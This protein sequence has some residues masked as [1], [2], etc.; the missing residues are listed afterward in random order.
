MSSNRQSGFTLIEVMVVVV[1]LGILASIIVPKIMDKPD[2]ARIVKARQDI[3]A[4]QSALDLYRL[5]NYV[6]P[7]TDQ[8]LDAL[9]QKPGGNPAAP[10]W[11]QYLPRLPTDP[12]G[13]P[14]QYLNPGVHGPVDI[15][16]YGA[17]AQPGGTGVNADIGNWDED[18]NDSGN[19]KG[20]S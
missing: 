17:D 15:W 4:I 1:I 5:D 13:H 16:S 18:G 6:Y 7:T 8:G 2:Q 12:W 11:K 20:G 19:S 10:H 9:V 14:Y 3:S